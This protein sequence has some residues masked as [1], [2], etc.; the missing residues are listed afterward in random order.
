VPTGT[1]QA[2]AGHPVAG[3]QG[4]N[5]PIHQLQ[6]KESY[7]C[8]HAPVREPGLLVLAATAAA[9][10]KKHDGAPGTSGAPFA[11]DVR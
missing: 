7:I 2:A 9:C 10:G 1:P 8:H 4:R 5:R 6:H 11:F 3:G